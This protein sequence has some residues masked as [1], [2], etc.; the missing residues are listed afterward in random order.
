[1]WKSVMTT[2]SPSACLTPATITLAAVVEQKVSGP[3]LRC[4]FCIDS[5]FIYESSAVQVR[6]RKILVEHGNERNVFK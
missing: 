5:T 3:F 1:M 4:V 2:A 6:H